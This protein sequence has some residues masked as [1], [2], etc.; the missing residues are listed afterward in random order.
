M[1][2]LGDPPSPNGDGGRPIPNQPPE[3]DPDWFEHYGRIIDAMGAGPPEPASPGPAKPTDPNHE[4]ALFQRW[5][6]AE[7]LGALTDFQW[8]V[9]G[10]MAQPTFGQFAGELKS[11]KSYVADCTAVAIASGQPIFD[12]FHVETPGPVLLYCGEGGR[13]PLTRRLVR[14]C[15]AMGV[16]FAT[17][18]LHVV[19]EAAPL[20]S[21]IFRESIERDLDEVSPVLT[22]IDPLYAY[23]GA[24]TAASNLHEEGALLTGIT[25]LVTHAGSNLFFVN[26]FNQTGGGRGLKRITMAGS[27]EHVDSW[28]L[29]AHRDTPDVAN[30]RF[31]LTLEIGSRQWG[32]TTWDLDLTLGRFNDETGTHDGDITWN[33]QP[34]NTNRQGRD[35][36]ARLANREM[37]LLHILDDHDPYT[38]TETK[39][40]TL[41]GGDKNRARQ[42][43]NNLTGT[44]LEWD[45]RKIPE[46]D[47]MV[48]R[49]VCARLETPGQ[50]LAA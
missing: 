36:E 29:L 28:Y 43:I 44:H 20:S 35:E 11:L 49:T 33:C 6:P 24:D 48:T 22:L 37:D 15:D 27:G 13:D 12:R 10:F 18:P 4:P 38:L 14:I 21:A 19:V 8:M 45:Q 16:D 31:Q 47:R 7:L 25:N 26:H 2:L 9:K 3:H 1:T 41:L 42:L 5:S 23:H 39:L 17:L 40:I 32:G 50:N 30:G 34:A 46:G